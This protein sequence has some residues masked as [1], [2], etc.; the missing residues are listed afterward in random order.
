M[1][2]FFKRMSVKQLEFREEKREALSVVEFVGRLY[3]D[4]NSSKHE[5]EMDEHCNTCGD[6]VSN[7]F[8]C[9]FSD[10]NVGVSHSY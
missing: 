8:C 10:S 1:T 2:L 6:A 9:C 3:V 4:L 5:D 7:V